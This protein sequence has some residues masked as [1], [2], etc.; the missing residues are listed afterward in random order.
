MHNFKFYCPKCGAPLTY[1]CRV[2]YQCSNPSCNYRLDDEN[3]IDIS[4]KSTGIAKAL[5]NLCSY[6][7]TF[8]AI[9]CSSMEAFIQSLKVKDP[10]VQRD[11][12]SKTGPF[13]YSIREIFD[14]WRITQTVHWK[15]IEIDRHS[16]EYTSL[17]RRAYVAL[18]A[19][20]PTFKYALLSSK[21]YRLS[22]SIGCIHKKETLLTP[23]EYINLLNHLRRLLNKSE[24]DEREGFKK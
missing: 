13:C 19:Q 7:F 8:E 16:E 6:P 5:S 9:H 20:S 11:I 17:L 10:D 3:T 12:C 14:D 15:G 23:A 22:H 24:D 4:F 21:G 18:L 1:G 2:L